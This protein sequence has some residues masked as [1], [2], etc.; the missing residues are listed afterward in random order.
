M[1]TSHYQR[2]K[3]ADGLHYIKNTSIF[4]WQLFF[5]GNNA[6]VLT[7]RPFKQQL[8]F[9]G[10][11]NWRLRRSEY[12]AVHLTPE[13]LWLQVIWRRRRS[14]GYAVLAAA[15]FFRLRRK[16]CGCA[17]SFGASPY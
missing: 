12:S 6:Y 16:F 9:G 14:G 8:L 4:W 11:P 10:L 5:S 17:G 2:L 13:S 7:A 15:P 1:H 3:L